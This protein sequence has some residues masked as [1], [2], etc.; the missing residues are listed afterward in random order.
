MPSEIVNIINRIFYRVFGCNFI[1][2]I[3]IKKV[4]AILLSTSRMQIAFNLVAYFA[5][6][7]VKCVAAKT[8]AHFEIC[9][10]RAV[11]SDNDLARAN[12]H[13]PVW[14]ES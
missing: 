5:W 8:P 3:K 2:R 6:K 4:V 14:V 1:E 10:H 13:L 11:I 9:R 7:E 12:N